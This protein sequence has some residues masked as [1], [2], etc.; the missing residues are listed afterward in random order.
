MQASSSPEFFLVGSHDT[1]PSQPFIPQ[2][3]FQLFSCAELDRP[4]DLGGRP[5]AQRAPGWGRQA[6]GPSTCSSSGAGRFPGQPVLHC[7]PGRPSSREGKYMDFFIS[8]MGMK[9]SSKG[10]YGKLPPVL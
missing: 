10:H 1:C 4:G 3:N 9:L 5:G 7:Q 2:I 8:K 6:P